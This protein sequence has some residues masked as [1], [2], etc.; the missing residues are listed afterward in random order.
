MKLVRLTKHQI[1]SVSFGITVLCYSTAAFPRNE[2]PFASCVD[3]QERYQIYDYQQTSTYS[4]TLFAQVDG[5]EFLLTCGLSDDPND[6]IPIACA[7]GRDEH[8]VSLRVH[9]VPI[10]RPRLA[11]IGI[12]ARGDRL[13]INTVV[14]LV[15]K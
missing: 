7:G 12:R 8:L 11:V 4:G 14:P 6:S 10:G 15:C 3:A 5:V 13:D 1:L 9:Q 2:A